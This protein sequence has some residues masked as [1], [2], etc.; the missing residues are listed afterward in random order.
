VRRT[1]RVCLLVAVLPLILM[2]VFPPRASA[3]PQLLSVSPN[4]GPPG[5]IVAITGTG[6]D[7]QYYSAGVQISFEQNFGNGVLQRFAD[8][9]TVQPDSAGNI[10]LTTS[11]PTSV[12]AGDV[13]SFDALIG[14]GGGARANFTVTAGAA[15][16][17]ITVLGLHGLNEDAGSPTIKDTFDKLQARGLQATYTSVPYSTVTTPDLLVFLNVGDRNPVLKATDD[18]NGAAQAAEATCH[19]A[20]LVLV[21][22][23]LGAWVID[24]WIHHAEPAQSD[25]IVAVMVFGDPQ[26]NWPNTGA[27]GIAR[28]GLYSKSLA[29]EPYRPEPPLGWRFGGFCATG[30][31][32]CGGGYGNTEHDHAQQNADALHGAG[33]HGSYVNG[34]TAQGADE[35]MQLVAARGN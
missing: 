12:R 10:H 28:H 34:A 5:T 15:A 18:L 17:S 35:V 31:P 33:T 3:E 1:L 9:V 19:P 2:T 7:P 8:D 32:I 21:G 13:I 26:W 22:Y 14:N 16:C 20:R 24:E 29:I 27:G 11:V 6:W 25:K 30:D 4:S 23:S